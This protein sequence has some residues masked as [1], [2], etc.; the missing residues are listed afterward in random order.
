MYSTVLL[1][2]DGGGFTAATAAPNPELTH[3][4]FLAC[5]GEVLLQDLKCSVRNEL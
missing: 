3:T 4:V 2:W 5:H 1:G